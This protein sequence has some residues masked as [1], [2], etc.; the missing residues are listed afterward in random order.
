MSLK[1][2]YSEILNHPTCS[3]SVAL[4]ILRIVA[5]V[6]MAI[7]GYGKIQ[8]PFNWMGEEA[9]VPGILQ[10]LAALSEFGGGIAWVIG[11]VTPLASLGIAITM[12]VAVFTH[13]A[14]GHP[15]VGMNG[16]YEMASLYLSIALVILFAGPGKYSIDSK[17]FK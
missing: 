10:F 1:T 14:Q 13:V 4:L 17:I 7:H 12:V 15:F 9:P 8:T 11:L 6:A 5:G 16:S 2:K 3:L